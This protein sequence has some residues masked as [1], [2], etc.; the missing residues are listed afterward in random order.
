MSSNSRSKSPSLSDSICFSILYKTAL[1]LYRCK[2][3]F[4]IFYNSRIFFAGT[5][6]IYA[7]RL[8]SRSHVTDKLNELN[9]FFQNTSSF[10]SVNLLPKSN[11]S[12]I[13]AYCRMRHIFFHSTREGFYGSRQQQM[14][15]RCLRLC[16]G[17]RRNLLQ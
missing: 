8:L 12:F 14:R 9:L 7:P 15:T 10:I 17:R 1:K 5:R 4:S 6:E 11:R 2:E 3:E 13:I 16:G